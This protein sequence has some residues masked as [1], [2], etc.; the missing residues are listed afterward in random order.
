MRPI[1]NVKAKD[2][3]QVVM[4]AGSILYYLGRIRTEFAVAINLV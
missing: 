3:K 1:E 4:P 2:A